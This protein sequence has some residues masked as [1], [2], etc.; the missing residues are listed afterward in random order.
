MVQVYLV[1]DNNLYY[2]NKASRRP[3]PLDHSKSWIPDLRSYR[4]GYIHYKREYD[5]ISLFAGTKNINYTNLGYIS[6][7]KIEEEGMWIPAITSHKYLQQ[8]E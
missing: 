5:N 8:G 7:S 4:V 2:H 6:F 1:V 3:K